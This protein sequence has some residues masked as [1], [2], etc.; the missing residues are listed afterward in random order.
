MQVV[1]CEATA[2]VAPEILQI[3]EHH[4]EEISGALAQLDPQS[5]FWVSLRES[6]LSV[7]VLGWKFTFS[8]EPDKLMLTSAEPVPAQVT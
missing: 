8:V 1:M 7:E 4:V 5:P 2:R 3:V 6:G